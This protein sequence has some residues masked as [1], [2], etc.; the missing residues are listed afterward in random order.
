MIR[1]LLDT[2]IVSLLQDGNP[3]VV[4][5]IA[6][7]PAEHIATSIITV[8]E[9][10]SGWFT[11]LRRVRRTEQLVPIYDRMAMTVRFLSRLP[12]LSFT[13]HSATVFDV[14]RQQHPRRGR[15]DLRIAAIALTSQAIL[16]T[17]NLSDFEDIQDL[18]TEDWSI[19]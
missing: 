2:D 15:M 1:Y 4:S 12:L 9:Q 8:E 7:V 17:R 19:A 18:V 16:V 6:S 13:G 11:L 5:H 14:L 3:H 10:L